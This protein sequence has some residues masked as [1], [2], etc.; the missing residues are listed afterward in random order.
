VA[1]FPDDEVLI[2]ALGPRT[3]YRP[4]Q[5]GTREIFCGPDA[6]P[7][8]STIRTP[9]G[10]Y[11]A[12]QAIGRLGGIRPDYVVVKAD[13]TGRNFPTGLAAFNCP[14]V[15]IVGNTQHLDCPI[16]RLLDYARH[17]RFDV[18]VSDHKRQ[19]LHFFAEAGFQRVGW[20]PALNI[21]PHAQP[22]T[23]ARR[24]DLVFVGQ[25]GSLHP[26]RRHVLEVLG[27]AK[28]PLR[29]LRAPQDEAAALYAQAQV[30][31]NVS[32]NGDLN[33]RVFE[34]LSSGGFLLT[35]RLGRGAGL[36]LLFAEGRDYAA[37][38][39]DDELRAQARRYLAEPDEALALARHG[40][41]PERRRA[42]RSLPRGRSSRARSRPSST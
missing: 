9:V 34:V 3:A 4:V 38:G 21:H 30:S 12:S 18:I 7:G 6:S 27:A 35:D 5:Y 11:D 32:L 13:A 37:F 40:A 28:I 19:H 23:T 31:L 26:Y 36:E 10:V 20:L 24:P 22:E 15:L 39:D 33:L 42:R 17:E 25:T 29:V 14:R 1:D 41:A 16:R 8:P 2:F